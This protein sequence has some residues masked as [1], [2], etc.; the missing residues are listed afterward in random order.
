VLFFRLAFDW[1]FF[2][3]CFRVAVG[4][5]AVYPSGRV[6]PAQFTVKMDTGKGQKRNVEAPSVKGAFV[7]VAIGIA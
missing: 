7:R 1:A 6:L 2:F 5:G 3:V 4:A